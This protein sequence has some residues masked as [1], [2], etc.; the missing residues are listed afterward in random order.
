MRTARFR[1]LLRLRRRRS[2]SRF[3]VLRSLTVRLSWSACR[4]AL[5]KNSRSGRVPACAGAGN[6]IMVFDTAP[7][8]TQARSFGKCEKRA[9]QST[10]I[11]GGQNVAQRR[12]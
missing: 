12:G 1:T 10:A 5:L 9:D 6:C 2:R 4:G 11:L 7:R 8:K 3:V